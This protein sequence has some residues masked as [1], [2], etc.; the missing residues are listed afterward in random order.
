MTRF[1]RELFAGR[2]GFAPTARF[3]S[4]PRLLGVTLDDL[5]AEEAFSVY[6]HPRVE[7]FRRDRPLSWDEFR[8]LLCPTGSRPDCP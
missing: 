7:L 8:R 5:G 6:D 1:Y 4:E 3:T 2:L